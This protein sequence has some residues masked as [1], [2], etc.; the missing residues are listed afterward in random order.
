MATINN[1]NSELD[2]LTAGNSFT[3]S[4]DDCLEYIKPYDTDIK[5]I[6]LN[7]RSINKN[8]NELQVLLHLTKIPFDVVILT[9]CWL[10]KV[11]NLPILQGYQSYLTNT[12][13]NQNDGIVIYV[14]LG[15]QI[16]VWEP[17][18][19]GGNFLVCEID[20][21][22]IAIV[23]VYRSPSHSSKESFDNFLY[24]LDEIHTK[25]ST[26]QNT[27]LIGD[28]NIDIKSNCR[29]DLSLEYLTL[30][31]SHGLIP[32]HLF[33]T[34]LANCLDH[35]LVKTNL[36]VTTLVLESHI[37]DHRPLVLAFENTN[38]RPK[39]YQFSTRVNCD[40]LKIE[41]ETTDFSLLYNILEPNLLM[42]TFISI[43]R[44]TI[45][46]HSVE[47]KT[48]RKQKIIKPWMTPGLLKCIK[49]RDKLHVKSRKAPDNLILKLTYTRYRNF[50]NGLLRKLRIAY[51]KNELEKAKNNPRALWKTIK[52]ITNSHKLKSSPI[53]LLKMKDNPKSSLNSVCNY[54]SNVG[55]NL[56]DKISSQTNTS[57]TFDGSPTS[58]TGKNPRL[59][60]STSLVLLEVDETEV[61]S[62]ILQLRDDCAI[63]WDGI[64]PKILKQSRS[65]LVPPLTHIINI[66]LQKGIFP[67]ALKRALVH[68]IHKGGNRSCVNNYRP[69]SV[70]TALSKVFERVLYN[71]LRK[72]L[73]RY[74]IIADNQYGFRSGVS[75]EDAVLD[76]TQV[77]AE[78]LDS[79]TKCL[80]IFLDLSKAFDTVSVPILISKLELVGIRGITLEI[81]KNYLQNRTQRVKVEEHLSEEEPVYYGVPQGSIL[82]PILFQIYV[83]DLCNMTLINAKIYAYADD[84][85]IIVNGPSWDSVKNSAELALAKITKW[86]NTNLLT[87]NLKKTCY[88]PF[89][90]RPNSLPDHIF[91]IIAHTCPQLSTPCP[92]SKLTRS[93]DVRYLG[94]QIDSGL[95]WDKQ[96]DVLITRTLRLIHTFKSLRSAAD[97][98]TLRMVYFALCQSIL[99]YC[100]AVWGGA[101][102]TNFLR[103]E[104]AQRAILK[105]MTRKP[106]RYPTSQLYLDCRVLTVRQLYVLQSI[107][108]R[109]RSVPRSNP[110]KRINVLQGTSH[111]TVFAKHQYYILSTYIYKKINKILN[112]IDLNKNE[113]K[114]KL[115]NWLLQQDYSKT[116]SL[117]TFIA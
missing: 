67:D 116:E 45:A 44:T 112:I 32:T 71:R 50:C 26:W 47:T 35:S 88:I 36:P 12:N 66:C 77:V 96:M 28:L 42:N 8:F 83:N 40:A 46:K 2:S 60:P 115:T 24:S 16:S 89:A 84:T 20:N 97:L 91:S 61:E 55:K 51:E 86:L 114:S 74:H 104:R 48:P 39:S 5:L 73:D 90:L 82:G 30:N 94:V 34:R 109:H 99:S 92:C 21:K 19:T 41:L 78:N 107:L 15:L 14:K 53:E 49:N 13:S 43:L 65:I 63:G 27:V 18:C 80:G 106:F 62:L 29:S 33:P 72:F 37:T 101:T 103:V 110:N 38:H 105:I 7:I 113:L 59:P 54:F 76:L 111:K 70:L 4:V 17:H 108:R 117:L 102:I 69:I 10:S 25:L 98:D 23:A 56:A 22:K 11:N 6:H 31:L 85:A 1:I 87:I 58:M 95:R 9:E 75:T 64:S 81:F 3:C 93:E 79:K 52:E 57:L 68:P 100:I